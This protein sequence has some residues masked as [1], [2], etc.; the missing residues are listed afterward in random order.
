MVRPLSLYGSASIE[1]RTAPSGSAPRAIAGTLVN[2]PGDIGAAQVGEHRCPFGFG[3]GKELDVVFEASSAYPWE[4]GKATEKHRVFIFPS[5]L[6]HE[7]AGPAW[8]KSPEWKSDLGDELV[9]SDGRSHTC[10][11]ALGWPTAEA[12][13]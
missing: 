9:F 12:R 1:P 11:K 6:I 8:A 10:R 3:R 4:G 13:T 2:A 5:E 7:S